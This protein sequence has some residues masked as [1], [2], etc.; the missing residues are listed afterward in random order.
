MGTFAGTVAETGETKK[1][2]LPDIKILNEIHYGMGQVMRGYTNDSRMPRWVFLGRSQYKRLVESTFLVFAAEMPNFKGEY[3]A[4]E[5][6]M[7]VEIVKVD[8]DD[9]LAVV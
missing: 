7:G 9:F 5:F 3:Q 4:T 8:R 6:V 2:E 1:L